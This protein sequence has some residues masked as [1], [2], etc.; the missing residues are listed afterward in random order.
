[1][2]GLIKHSLEVSNSQKGSE[3]QCYNLGPLAGYVQDQLPTM[4][5]EKCVGGCRPGGF[6]VTIPCRVAV[7]LAVN[8]PTA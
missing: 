1:M 3:K 4:I 6:S 2:R 8:V 5:S 7:F